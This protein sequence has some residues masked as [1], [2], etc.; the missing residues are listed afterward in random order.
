MG[1]M[2]KSKCTCKKKC[3]KN[4][5]YFKVVLYLRNNKIY[6]LNLEQNAYLI[7]LS[8]C[9]SLF[10]IANGVLNNINLKKDE[11]LSGQNFFPLVEH[12][13]YEVGIGLQSCLDQLLVPEKV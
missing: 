1:E 6:H 11:N 7:H 3:K 10:C 4:C 5:K 8:W 2:A 13:V 12:V 9:S